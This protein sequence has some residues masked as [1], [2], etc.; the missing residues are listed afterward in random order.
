MEQG[1]VPN[2]TVEAFAEVFTEV[3]TKVITKAIII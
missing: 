2:L 3:T 1:I